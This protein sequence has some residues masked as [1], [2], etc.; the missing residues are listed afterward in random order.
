ME[1]NAHH[2]LNRQFTVF[3]NMTGRNLVGKQS[4]KMNSIKLARRCAFLIALGFYSLQ[5]DLSNA[6]SD[7]QPFVQ[8]I[9][10]PARVSLWNPLPG[11]WEAL[12]SMNE[13]RNALNLEEEWYGFSDTD[14]WVVFLSGAEE[15]EYLPVYAREIIEAELP[16]IGSRPMSRL[17]ITFENDR[18]LM[19]SF[20]LLDQFSMPL[21]ATVCTVAAA[22]MKSLLGS[23]ERERYEMMYDCLPDGL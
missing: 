17:K 18:K 4:R 11:F 21:S 15:V 20:V 6:A 9:N 8:M 7:D 13:G 19:V 5:P 23:S 3:R 22:L 10:G 14:V 12:I 1:V 2:C 16:E